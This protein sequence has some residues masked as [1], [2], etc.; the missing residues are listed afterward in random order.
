M[1]NSFQT[2]KRKRSYIKLIVTIYL[3]VFLGVILLWVGHLGWHTIHLFNLVNNIKVQ[4]LGANPDALILKIE[5]VAE[6][7]RS[8]HQDLAPF[9]PVFNALQGVPLLGPYLG[10]VEPLVT[11]IDDLAQAGNEISKGLAPLLDMTQ[12]VSPGFS[13]PERL[14]S[15]LQAGKAN[16]DNAEVLV[17]SASQA[18]QRI[19]P[20]LI[21]GNIRA[22]YLTLDEKFGL[23]SMGV[24]T[25]QA[26]PSFLGSDQ[27]KSYLLLAQNR[28][29]L[30]GTGGF[31]SG[32]GQVTVEDGRISR[33]DL[34]DSYSIDDFSKTYP[35]PPDALKRYML[36]DYWVTRDSNW[37]PDFPASAQKAQELYA[38]STGNQTQGVIAF[39][40]LA[41]KRI[42]EVIGPI[43]LPGIDEPVSAENIETYLSQA[44]APEP[45]EGLSMEW[46][47]HRK[48]FMQQL[49]LVLLDKIFKIEDQGPMI[50]L[51]KAVYELIA[52]GQVL[53]YFNDPELEQALVA[54]GLD[55][56]VRPGSGD[57]LYLVDSNVG[58]NKV[59]AVI[60]RSLT[61]S[62]DLSVLNN[63]KG[64]ARITY[65]H[66]GSG[67]E[68]CKQE[69]SYGTGTYEDM[70]QRCYLDYWRL[71]VPEGSLLTSSI[72][73][74]VPAEALL[75][76]QGYSGLVDTL[77]GE[78]GSEVFAGL[79]MLSQGKS[80]SINLAYDLPP[81]VLQ[82]GKSGYVEYFLHIGVQSG[83]QT[84]PFV[85]EVMLPMDSSLVD[86]G[87]GWTNTAGS[88][89]T[90]QGVLDR[91]TNLHLT[92]KV[93]HP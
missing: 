22:Y 2:Q 71:Y 63:P 66:S 52:Q 65:Q 6:D 36:A 12:D 11:Y 82:P 93:N 70:Q 34:G 45:G 41:I 29:E 37:S 9:M 33:F 14:S 73:Q 68:P 31:I 91:P 92:I 85:L 44:W 59:D 79:L 81:E 54:A 74:P 89:W 20:E 57:F 84:L 49:G 26:A 43:S 38:I 67:D 42:L 47:L 60:R 25:L 23:I 35:A 10:Q 40:Q 50:A 76:N 19:R 72:S 7:T 16:F 55:G 88:S 8:I 77:A 51:A 21:P 58:F 46:W 86:P 62:L 30:R 4:L 39:N 3:V 15:V 64:T 1:T 80:A 69:I 61:Y 90:W 27:P 18:R 48:D 5:Q 83:V 24:H 13:L 53:L 17:A 87:V 56:A 75:S 28:D 78:A 32:I